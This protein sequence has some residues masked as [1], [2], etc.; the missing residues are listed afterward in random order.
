MKRVNK[1]ITL[2]HIQTIKALNDYLSEDLNK[3]IN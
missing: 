1:C 2:Q 3:I